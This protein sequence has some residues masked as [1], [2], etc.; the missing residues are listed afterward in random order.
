MRTRG[1][2]ILGVLA[3]AAV[4]A[5]SGCANQAQTGAG[6][7]AVLGAGL[8]QAIGGDTESTLLGA[9][10]GGGLGYM[11]GNEEDK[12][13]AAEEHEQDYNTLYTLANTQV[14]NIRN[15]NGSISQVRLHREGG[16]W[17]GPRDEQYLTLPSEDQLRPAYGF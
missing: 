9:I 3:L 8:G 10:I 4:L 5:L 14:V 15:S 13:L 7:G 17:I 16:R 6:L 12:R 1:T 2:R 11:F